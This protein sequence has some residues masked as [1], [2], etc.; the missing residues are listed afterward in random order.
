[1]PHGTSQFSHYFH[2]FFFPFGP[3]ILGKTDS[4]SLIFQSLKEIK[5]TCPR[6]EL[7]AGDSSRPKTLNLIKG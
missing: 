2:D 6:S 5:V 1:M 7:V 3:L 4:I